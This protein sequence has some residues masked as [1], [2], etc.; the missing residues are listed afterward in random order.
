MN[1]RSIPVLICLLLLG[2]PASGADRE[3]ERAYRDGRRLQRDG[4]LREAFEAY[5]RAAD[6]EPRDQRF[7]VAREM[8]RQQAAIAYVNAGERLM[9]AGRYADAIPE[10]EQAIIDPNSK[11]VGPHIIVLV[12]DRDTSVLQGLQTRIRSNDEITLIPVAHGG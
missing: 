7:V 3:A 1:A 11:T 6:R 8:T 10:F 12:N 5:K 2:A 4:K 9:R